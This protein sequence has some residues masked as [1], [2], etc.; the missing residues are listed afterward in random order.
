MDR[1]FMFFVFFLFTVF[2][3]SLVQTSFKIY[4]NIFKQAS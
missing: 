3:K 1:V 4:F 2:K